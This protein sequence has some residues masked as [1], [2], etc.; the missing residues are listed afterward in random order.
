MKKK[1]LK[2]AGLTTIISLIV[3][4]VSYLNPADLDFINDIKNSLQD[5]N[6]ISF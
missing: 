1:T 2:K 3:L 6:Q 4:T 5:I